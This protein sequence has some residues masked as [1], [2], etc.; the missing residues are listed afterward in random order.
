MTITATAM[1]PPRG[2]ASTNLPRKGNAWRAGPT[3]LIP[4]TLLTEDRNNQDRTSGNLAAAGL[5]ISGFRTKRHE[6]A[7]THIMEP[8]KKRAL[9]S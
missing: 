9:E 3:S 2:R 8:P 7:A 5:Q 6:S 4:S 1:L